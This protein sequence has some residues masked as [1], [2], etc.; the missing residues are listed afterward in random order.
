MKGINHIEI[1][2][3][4]V[5]VVTLVVTCLAYRY[6][7]KSDKKRIKSEL[8]R[9]ESQLR[10]L[11]N[12]FRFNGMGNSGMDELRIKKAMLESEIEQ[13]RKEL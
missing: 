9:K 5:A 11:E 7:R 6:T 13:L 2:T 8:A 4:V 3:L 1:L 10:S 12:G